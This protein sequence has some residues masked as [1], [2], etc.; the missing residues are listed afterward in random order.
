MFVGLKR[1]MPIRPTSN[2]KINEAVAA[3]V[4]VGSDASNAPWVDMA[5][6]NESN[7]GKFHSFPLFVFSR[8]PSQKVAKPLL[9]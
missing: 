5:D 6:A 8:S 9:K 1:P 2:N 4:S 7:D 3:N